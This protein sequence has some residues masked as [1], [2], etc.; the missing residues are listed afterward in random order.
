[1]KRKRTRPL[2]FSRWSPETDET[3]S[4]SYREKNTHV[5]VIGKGGKTP[6]SRFFYAIVGKETFC[7]A[8]RLTMR[9]KR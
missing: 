5:D 4:W 8:A 2:L 9:L 3:I 7:Q 6:R 1:V